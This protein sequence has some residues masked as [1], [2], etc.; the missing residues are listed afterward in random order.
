MYRVRLV[1]LFFISYP[2]SVVLEFL[3]AQKM[4]EYMKAFHD[5]GI[6]GDILLEANDAVLNELG[7]TKALHKVKLKTKFKKFTSNQK[8]LA[9][10]NNPEHR[11]EETQCMFVSV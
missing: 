4:T 9:G 6:D 11:V 1:T 3:E 5:H 10:Q 8:D 2:V 7:V